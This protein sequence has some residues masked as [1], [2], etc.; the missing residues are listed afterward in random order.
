MEKE[1]I[2]E[3]EVAYRRLADLAEKI[4][5]KCEKHRQHELGWSDPC[6]C[7]LNLGDDY[8]AFEPRKEGEEE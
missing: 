3:V 6:E 8:F 1:I 2:E 7:V 5:Q 4:C